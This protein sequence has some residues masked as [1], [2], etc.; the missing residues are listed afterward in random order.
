MKNCPSCFRV[1]HP[2]C[3][4]TPEEETAHSRAGIL[5]EQTPATAALETQPSEGPPS[6]ETPAPSD[7]ARSDETGMPCPSA[8]NTMRAVCALC[9]MV[10][11]RD[12]VCR[13]RF[14]G[15]AERTQ[16]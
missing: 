2:G 13:R 5:A 10:E 6:Q 8:R 12:K 9:S 4:L 1:F 16:S 14:R 15:S 7:D 11:L 3:F